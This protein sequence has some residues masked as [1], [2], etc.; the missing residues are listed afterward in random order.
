[1]YRGREIMSSFVVLMI[2]IAVCLTV[3]NII[4]RICSFVENTRPD[5]IDDSISEDEDDDN[6][7]NV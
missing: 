3:F 5:C 6:A 1:M 2:V 7:P 4:D